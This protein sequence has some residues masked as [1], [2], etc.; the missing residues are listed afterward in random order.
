MIDEADNYVERMLDR[1]DYLRTERKDREM[2]AAMERDEVARSGKVI[3]SELSR[4]RAENMRFRAFVESIVDANGPYPSLNGHPVITDA[5]AALNPVVGIL[6]NSL[7][8]AVEP[9]PPIPQRLLDEA[10][11]AHLRSIPA[12][13]RPRFF[14]E[15]ST[16]MKW[17]WDGREMLTDDG[18]TSIFVSPDEIL[19]CLDVVEVDEDGEPLGKGA[20]S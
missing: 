11:A 19:E 3:Q 2:E 7:P 9:A 14:L 17:R 4:L 13:P 1:A 15:T 10:A 8:V 16:G 18:E 5:Y 12:A 6:R 20:L